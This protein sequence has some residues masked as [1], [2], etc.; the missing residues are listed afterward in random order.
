MLKKIQLGVVGLFAVSCFAAAS[1]Q[2]GMVSPDSDA[3][4][5]QGKELYATGQ[6]MAALDKFMKV[7][8][9][10]P[11]QPEAREYLR[12]VVDEL[13]TKRA[14]TDPKA[15]QPEANLPFYTSAPAPQAVAT[16]PSPAVDMRTQLRQ[17]QL[18]ATDLA[19]I[20]GVKLKMDS[21][22]AMV[23]IQTP[24]LFADNTGGL[25][26]EGVPILDRVAAWLK[27]FGYDPVAIHCLPEER[28]TAGAGD[29]LFLH[30]Y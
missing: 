15:T 20:P 17:R 27:T 7:L 28:D 3:V 10:D 11:R 19:A 30:R 13:R 9:R 5:E 29:S 24:L 4:L 21:R 6:Y 22:N 26:E 16:V 23:E 2:S 14:A 1:P 8:R 12:L 18:F 25:R